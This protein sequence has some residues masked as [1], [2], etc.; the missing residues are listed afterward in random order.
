MFPQ[1]SNEYEWRILDRLA[2]YTQKT[3]PQFFARTECDMPSGQTFKEVA[4]V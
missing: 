3:E 2:N 4:F 1:D